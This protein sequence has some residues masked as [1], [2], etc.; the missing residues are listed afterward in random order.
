MI[1]GVIFDLD[2][3]LVRTDG[4]HYLAWKQIADA[5]EIYFDERI[6]D[7]LRG[8]S[9]MESL[10]IVLE[11]ARRSYTSAE[12]QA[13]AD[14]KNTIYRDLLM[15]MGPGDVLPGVGSI[16][17]ALRARDVRL[18][19][20]SS[21]KNAGT[22]LDRCALTRLFDA[23]VDGNDISRS[24]PDPE[25]FLLA[26]TRL[27]VPPARCLVVEDAVAGI[28]AARRAG[29]GYVGI[30]TPET[31]PGVSPLIGGLAEVDAERLLAEP[32]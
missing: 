20:G 3:V 27:G 26:A 10:D 32:R 19:V 28:E 5:E 12:K 15:G 31:M 11:R 21:S 24:K 23:V 29:M 30:G 14:R 1:Q 18:A 9:R 8:V 7:R 25:V 4:L 2:G 6:N 13:M 17:D 16:L 22:I